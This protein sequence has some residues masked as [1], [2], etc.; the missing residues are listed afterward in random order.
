MIPDYIERFL[1][2]LGI[3]GK[4]QYHSKATKTCVEKARMLSWPTERIIKAVYGLVNWQFYGFIFP[5]FCYKLD[6]GTLQHVFEQV[7]LSPP[8][9]TLDFSFSRRDI[10][11]QMESGTCSPFIT[12]EDMDYLKAI[13]VCDVPSLEHEIVDVSLG[14]HGEEARRTSLHLPYGGIYNI[15]RHQFK[16]KVHKVLFWERFL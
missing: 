2:E 3:E 8:E 15:L 9:S 7:S 13:F 11:S 6:L 12:K 16:D 10:P 4:I 5:E 14:G 1:G